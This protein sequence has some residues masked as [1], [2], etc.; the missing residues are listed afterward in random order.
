M[1]DA[2]TCKR[3][4]PYLKQR[5]VTLSELGT[6]QTAIVQTILHEKN[7]KVSRKTV[8]LTIKK[9]KQVGEVKPSKQGCRPAKLND[10]HLA[11]LS[12]CLRENS[13]LSGN[14]LAMK[15]KCVFGVSVS[16]STVK[17]ARRKL[18]WVSTTPAYCQTVRYVNR[19]MRLDYAIRCVQTNEKFEDVIFTDE[20][21]IKIQ[22]TANK[23][24]HKLGE[25]KPLKG[26][27]KHPF[28][29]HVWAGISRKGPT[30]IHIF[31]GIMDS[32][33]YQ[34]I[35]ST[36]FIPFVKNHYEDHHRLMQD[37]DHKHVSKSTKEFMLKND[38]NH[39]ILK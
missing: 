26:K 4:S 17:A 21:T 8:N 3:L 32:I 25:E 23:C 2:V 15:L 27:P 30:D 9:S 33:Y 20:S 22:N 39:W 18:G 14:E 1:A 31:S 37:N 36:Y 5:I 38:I 29:L 6:K 13:E 11:F 12:L 19:P 24:F 16:T 7:V 28:Q 35:L 34:E 10:D